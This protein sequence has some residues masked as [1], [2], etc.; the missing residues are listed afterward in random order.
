M[1]VS[2]VAA[3]DDVGHVAPDGLAGET[4]DIFDPTRSKRT[5]K[6]SAACEKVSARTPAD[7]PV[8][9]NGGSAVW[10]HQKTADGKTD[11][12]ARAVILPS[13]CETDA[14]RIWWETREMFYRL[15]FSKGGRD[16]CKYLT[17]ASTIRRFQPVLG[18]YDVDESEHFRWSRH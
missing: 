4:R 11:F 3:T 18:F 10:I 13:A 17:H 8:G 16:L 5:G 12:L 15:G 14:V 6:S 9:F 7:L 1:L 2:E